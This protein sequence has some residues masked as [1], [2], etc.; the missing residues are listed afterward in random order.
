M[1]TSQHSP[2]PFR[3]NVVSGQ[4]DL[5]RGWRDIYSISLRSSLIY[6]G[7]LTELMILFVHCYSSNTFLLKISKKLFEGREKMVKFVRGP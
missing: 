7:S 4:Y 6:T 1:E 2:P 5:Q 3:C